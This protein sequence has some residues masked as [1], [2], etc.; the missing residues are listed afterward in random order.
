MGDIAPVLL[1]GVPLLVDVHDAEYVKTW[2]PPL[3][4]P[5]LNATEIDAFPRVTLVIV[6]GSG[7]VAGTTGLDGR[8]ALLVPTS[9]VAVTVHV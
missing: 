9:L 8:D 4:A 3:L 1:P 5:W 2:K 7:T 6:G